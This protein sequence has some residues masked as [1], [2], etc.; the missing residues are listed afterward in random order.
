MIEYKLFIFNPARGLS[1]NIA[2]YLDGV[3]IAI[4]SNDGSVW[5][6]EPLTLLNNYSLL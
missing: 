4:I 2:A 3:Q 1:W 6:L 5:Q